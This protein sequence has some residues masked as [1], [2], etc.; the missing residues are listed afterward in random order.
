ML[1]FDNH[2]YLLHHIFFPFLNRK[3]I[4]DFNHNS[5][6]LRSLIQPID[7]NYICITLIRNWSVKKEK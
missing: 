4:N 5:T 1:K 3:S 6:H 7:S 2:Q